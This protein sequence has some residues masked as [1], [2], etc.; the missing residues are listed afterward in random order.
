[1]L[2]LF[3]LL[4]LLVL[5]CRSSSED[6]DDPYS[7]KEQ[8]R[9]LKQSFGHNNEMKKSPTSPTSPSPTSHGNKGFISIIIML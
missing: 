6:S 3:L 1:M 5:F 8:R 9:A 7:W 2:L 4:L